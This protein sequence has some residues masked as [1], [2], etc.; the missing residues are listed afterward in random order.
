MLD[1][2]YPFVLIDRKMNDVKT[3]SVIVDNYKGAHEAVTHLLKQGY[4]NIATFAVTPIHVSTIKDRI[5]GY[6]HSLKDFGVTYNKKYLKEISFTDV[7]KSVKN[8]LTSLL[9]SKDKIDALFAVNNN[10]A[11]A[12]LER[13]NEMKI[14]IPEDLAFVCFDDLEVF[15]FSRPSI[16][17]VAQPIEEICKKTVEILLEEIKMKDKE[18]EKKQIKL[19]T[20][21]AVRRSTVS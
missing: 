20:S 1:E 3:N 18:F 12:C 16:T 9:Q 17:A 15:K 2:K 5:E 4:K 21:L 6:L 8:E 13:L 14:R 10:I 7:K 19:S 11:I